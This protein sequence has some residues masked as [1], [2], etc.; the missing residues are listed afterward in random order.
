MPAL[1][2]ADVLIGTAKNMLKDLDKILSSLSTP[3]ARS[4]QTALD[5]LIKALTRTLKTPI[6]FAK[7]A[8]NG[9]RLVNLAELYQEQKP[10]AIWRNILERTRA[11]R[12]TLIRAAR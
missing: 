8:E 9:Q 12:D 2:E 4:L 3:P 7:A 5:P 6:D 10:T 1:A 11:I